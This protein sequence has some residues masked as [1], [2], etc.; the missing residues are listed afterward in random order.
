MI[1]LLV[2]I[3]LFVAPLNDF[4]KI[5]KINELKKEAAEAY[6]EENYQKAVSSYRTLIEEYKVEEESVLLNYSN[7]LYKSGDHETALSHYKKLLFSKNPEIKSSAFLQCGI[8]AYDRK[9][10]KEALDLFKKAL[11]ANPSNEAA[12]YNYELL[13]KLM[14]DQEN[15]NKNNQQQQPSEFAIELKKKADKLV[16]QRKYNEALQIMVEGMKK[17]PSVGYY[18]SFMGRLQHITNIDD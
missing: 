18:Q 3:L 7:A 2:S 11:R 8:I 5:A 10:Q 9:Q 6:K 15:Q 17:D 16:D 4:N 13:K 1:K 14:K 12:R